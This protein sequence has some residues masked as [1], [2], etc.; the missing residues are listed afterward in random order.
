MSFWLSRNG[1]EHKEGEEQTET[2]ILSVELNSEGNFIYFNREK[3]SRAAFFRCCVCS[4]HGRTRGKHLSCL[5]CRADLE[6]GEESRRVAATRLDIDRLFHNLFTWN[7]KK[8]FRARCKAVNLAIATRQ[9]SRPWAAHKSLINWR[10]QRGDLILAELTSMATSLHF[11]LP[12]ERDRSGF[13]N[14]IWVSWTRRRRGERKWKSSSKMATRKIF[15]LLDTTWR[16]RIP[17]YRFIS[18]TFESW[19]MATAE[20]FCA[21]DK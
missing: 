15:F 16:W 5:I 6:E 13:F 11:L 10:R 2:L 1:G 17:F 8:H 18:L 20:Y 21:N 4:S 19:F 12:P 9:H 7:H 14:R 3:A